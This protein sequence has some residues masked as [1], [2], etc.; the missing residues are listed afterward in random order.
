MFRL[1]RRALVHSLPQLPYPVEAG[2]PPVISPKQL[3]LHYNKHH[4]A[5]VVKLN[6]MAFTPTSKGMNLAGLAKE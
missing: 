6:G 3:D 2:I 4:N 5:Y 1:G